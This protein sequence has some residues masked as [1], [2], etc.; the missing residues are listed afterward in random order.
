MDDIKHIFLL[1]KNSTVSDSSL[2]KQKPKQTKVV[3]QSEEWVHHDLANLSPIEQK[4]AVQEVLNTF[5]TTNHGLSPPAKILLRTV[6]I[7]QQ[8][9]KTQ[10]IEKTL[11]DV[12]RFIDTKTIFEKLR[13]SEFACFYCKEPVLL[14]Y[15][16]CRDPKQWTLERVDNQFGHNGD[17]VEIACLQCNVRRRTMYHERYQMTKQC[18]IRKLTNDT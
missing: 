17:N 10:D 5:D 6:R 15:A 16:Y 7:K 11:F 8:G 9:Y 14:F 13:D 2:A 4:Q 12:D 18:V 3:A 1:P